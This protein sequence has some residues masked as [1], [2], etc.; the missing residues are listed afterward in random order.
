MAIHDIRKRREDLELITNYDLIASAHALLEGID[1]DVASSKIANKYVEATDYLSPSDDG[2][3]CQQWYGKVY[4][5]PPSGAYFWDKKNEK[6]KMTR[7]SSPSLTSSH[8]VWF[9]KLYNSWLAGDIK[10]GLYFTNCP[11]MIRYEQKI[12]DFPICILKTA[13]LLLK[14]TSE[15]VSAHKTCT[16]FL[17]YIPPMNDSANSTEKF[18]DI[19]SEKGKIL[20]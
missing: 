7:A 18:I 19:Y 16:S 11:D 5:F 10:Q 12:F 15:G 3:N 8:A 13:P 2:L 1:L 4:L 14:N 9:R 20:C 6:W 17:V